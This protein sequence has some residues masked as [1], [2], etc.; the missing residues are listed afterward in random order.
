MEQK[1]QKRDELFQS[2]FAGQDN[3]DNF[4]LAEQERKQESFFDKFV[5]SLDSTWKTSFDIIMLIASCYNTFSQAYYAAFGNP[6]NTYQVILDYFIEILFFLDFIFCFCQEYKDEETY[7]VVSDIKKIAKHYLKG[8]CIFDLLANIPFELFFKIKKNSRD[9]EKR[10]LRL[11]KLLR[12]P[13]L[14]A[15]LNVDRIK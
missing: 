9:D 7:T 11:F 3:H 1:R 14:F 8:S 6:T 2:F 5:I 4:D 15:L 12:L 10:L 13:R